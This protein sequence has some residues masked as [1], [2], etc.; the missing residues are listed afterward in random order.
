MYHRGNETE[1]GYT[2]LAQIATP[3]SNPASGFDRIYFKSDDFLY[4]LNSAGTEVQVGGVST[5]G[6]ANVT[7]EVLARLNFAILAV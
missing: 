7:N 2:D 6:M 4:R 1:S 5:V 3:G